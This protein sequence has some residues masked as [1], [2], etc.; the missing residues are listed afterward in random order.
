MKSG[1]F[2]E[3]IR[4]AF[5]TSIVLENEREVGSRT[6]PA[7]DEI[8]RYFYAKISILLRSNEGSYILFKWIYLHVKW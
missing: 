2:I 1:A 4:L 7:L 3:F 6:S 8:D 5:D